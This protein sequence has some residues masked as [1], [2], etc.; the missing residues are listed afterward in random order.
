MRER[1]ARG[2][3]V[4]ETQ[5]GKAPA[6]TRPYA[7]TDAAVQVGAHRSLDTVYGRV[8]NMLVFAWARMVHVHAW[9]GG[10]V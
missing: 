6:A 8:R 9:L 1:Q 2:V 4:W 5:R 7:A 10:W 3:K